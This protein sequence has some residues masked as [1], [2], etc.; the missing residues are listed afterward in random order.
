M[1]KPFQI[2]FGDWLSYTLLSR[3]PFSS[4]SI[5]GEPTSQLQ[6]RPD[7]L[8]KS[9]STGRNPVS[10]SIFL[11]KCGICSVWAV[12]IFTLEKGYIIPKHNVLPDILFN[13]VTASPP[14]S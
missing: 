11:W 13:I 9:Y 8:Y 7:V 10:A 4:I 5:Y 1:G 3:A 6:R 2:I 14:T 12:A